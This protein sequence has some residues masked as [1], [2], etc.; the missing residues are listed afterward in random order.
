[1]A[2]K[3]VHQGITKKPSRCG[4]FLQRKQNSSAKVCAEEFEMFGCVG[5]IIS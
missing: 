5:G 2:E 3:G 1:M 4:G